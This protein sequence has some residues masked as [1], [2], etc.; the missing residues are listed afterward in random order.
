MSFEEETSGLSK[1][2][3]TIH[4]D[5]ETYPRQRLTATSSTVRMV[6][7]PT[8]TPRLNLDGVGLA[9]T[10]NPYLPSQRWQVGRYLRVIKVLLRRQQR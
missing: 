5:V 8:T 10:A 1:E 9:D 6:G 2:V 7:S 3:F 4:L